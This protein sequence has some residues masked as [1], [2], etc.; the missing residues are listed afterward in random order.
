MGNGTYIEVRTES[1]RL[2]RYRC[3]IRHVA[4]IVVS[5]FMRQLRELTETRRQFPIISTCLIG[6]HSFLPAS[7]ES[8]V[9]FNTEGRER[10][11]SV[12][13]ILP[14]KKRKKIEEGPWFLVEIKGK[15]S[16]R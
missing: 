16:A 3:I 8:V 14:R 13:F 5:Y 2:R 15:N 10:E 12:E 4:R 6:F 7:P 11:R 9:F 1:L